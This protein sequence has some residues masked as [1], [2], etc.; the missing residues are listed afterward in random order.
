MGVEERKIEGPIIGECSICKRKIYND[1]DAIKTY[2]PTYIKRHPK[3]GIKRG[4]DKIT[5]TCKECLKKQ[6]EMDEINII[7]QQKKDKSNAI[8]NTII[9][10]I[11]LLLLFIGYIIC[12]IVDNSFFS[13]PV[14]VILALLTVFIPVIVYFT[15]KPKIK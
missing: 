8:K 10:F 1:I 15:N 4:P 11:V 7:E 12:A 13:V 6:K 14:I 2:S 5:Y 9:V 3:G